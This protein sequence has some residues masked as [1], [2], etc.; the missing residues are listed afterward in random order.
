MSLRKLYVAS[1]LATLAG[2]VVAQN[3]HPSNA[4]FNGTL[5]TTAISERY[6]DPNKVLIIALTRVETATTSIQRRFFK[7]NVLG[8]YGAAYLAERTLPLFFSRVAGLIH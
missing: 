6:K 4:T 3:V 1:S 2:G 5:Q 8:V 7:A